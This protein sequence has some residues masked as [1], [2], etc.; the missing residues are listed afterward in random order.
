MKKRGLSNVI[1]IVLI[2][3]SAI[4]AVVTVW[5]FV[6]KYSNQRSEVL[7]AKT[8]LLVENIEI[9]KVSGDFQD[10][11]TLTLTLRRGSAKV[12]LGNYTIIQRS[13]D[14]VFIIDSTI[15]M[16]DEIDETI[17]TIQQFISKLE[18]EGIDYKLALVEFKDYEDV[19]CGYPGDGIINFPDKIHTFSGGAQLTSDSLEYINELQTIIAEGWSDAPESHLSAIDAAMTIT[20]RQNS[21]KIFIMLSDA[22]PHAKD[23]IDTRLVRANY[24]Q[25]PDTGK[26]TTYNINGCYQ[27]PEYIQDVTDDL[28]ANDVT[29]FYISTEIGLCENRIMS[30]VMTEETGGRFFDYG[31]ANGVQEVI[32]ELADLIVE[33][34]TSKTKFSYLLV[35]L[36]NGT[37]TETTKIL[38]PPTQPLETK[39]YDI[40]TSGSFSITNIN[41]VEIYPVIVTESG[42]EVISDI[43]VDVWE[44]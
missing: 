16:G 2:I 17:N 6:L 38:D 22:D 3:L 43:P 23:C 28:V 12:I 41:K 8:Q 7:D 15:S 1:L 42:Q 39:I 27:G 24:Y 4:A 10:P 30:E 33:E 31:Q 11:D 32:T 29:L 18:E 25:D 36:S 35:V 20:Y 40:P 26:A 34:Y 14:I 5:N 21:R 13:A 19:E 9:K 37:W 44:V